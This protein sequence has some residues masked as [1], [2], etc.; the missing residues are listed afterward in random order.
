MS[1][2]FQLVF[3]SLFIKQLLTKKFE[4]LNQFVLKDAICCEVDL[5]LR[6]VEN[7]C[8]LQL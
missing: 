4:K 3:Q 7:S 2:R 5:A 8:R 6:K 1:Q